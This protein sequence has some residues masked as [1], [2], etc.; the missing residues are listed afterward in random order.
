M[1]RCLLS[2]CLLLCLA[3]LARSDDSDV[4]PGADQYGID[5]PNDTGLAVVDGKVLLVKNRGRE[6]S[7]DLWLIDRAGPRGVT[8]RLRSHNEWRG[9]YLSFDP[10]G[11]RKTVFLSKKRTKGSYWSLHPGTRRYE[12]LNTIRATAGKLKGWYLDGG[13]KLAIM[14][15]R[16]S[17]PKSRGRS[18]NS[19]SMSSPL[20]RPG[21][22]QEPA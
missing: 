12:T 22:T 17:S 9:W 3:A 15:T 5:G 14:L 10:T 4:Q 13:A 16:P 11:K 19:P 6:G 8:L 7:S 21:S 18:Q 1:S 2:A 20:E